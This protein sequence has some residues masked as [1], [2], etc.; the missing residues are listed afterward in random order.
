MPKVLNDFIK[1]ATDP[2]K[3]PMNYAEG[4][5]FYT[6][7]TKLSSEEFQQLSGP[8][9][10]QVADF[11]R[12]LG[13]S[14]NEV[15]ERAEQSRQLAMKEFGSAMKMKGAMDIAKSAGITALKGAAG[16]GGAGAAYEI[17]RKLTGRR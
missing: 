2:A 12:K 5:D 8:M 10:A 15:A 16:A 13:A 17:Y 7:A 11:T 9:K 6:N 4:Q 14:L 1:R 3:P